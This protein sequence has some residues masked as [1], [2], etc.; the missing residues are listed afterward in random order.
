[1]L[2]P[3]VS[4]P[5]VLGAAVGEKGQLFWECKPW[6]AGVAVGGEAQLC[7]RGT[8]Q[9]LHLC[10]AAALLARQGT[11]HMCRHEGT[12]PVHLSMCRHPPHVVAPTRCK[13]TSAPVP[14]VHVHAAAGL[15]SRVAAAG[16]PIEF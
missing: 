14:A 13:G 6:G 4:K 3:G 10:H 12:P 15:P 11:P 1:M 5:Q 2:A 8:S 16:Q 7:Q 9:A